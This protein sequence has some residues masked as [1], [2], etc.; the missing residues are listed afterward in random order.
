MADITF[1]DELQFDDNVT[2][3]Q[4]VLTPYSI[5]KIS[6]GE[7]GKVTAS[8]DS[9][10]MDQAEAMGFKK[11]TFRVSK[12]YDKPN[13]VE[14][15]NQLL[16]DKGVNP[17]LAYKVSRYMPYTA[18]EAYDKPLDEIGSYSS[19]PYGA[20]TRDAFSLPGRLLASYFPNEGE[21]TEDAIG[22][23][24]EDK[25]TNFGGSIVRSPSTGVASVLA[26]VAGVVGGVASASPWLAGALEGLTIGAGTGGFNYATDKD[27]TALDALIESVGSALLGSGFKAGSTA[28]MNKAKAMISKAGKFLPQQ[29]DYIYSKL[30]KTTSGTE[31]NLKQAVPERIGDIAN[32]DFTPSKVASKPSAGKLLKEH[33]TIKYITKDESGNILDNVSKDY[34]ETIKQGRISGSLNP[35]Q[36]QAKEAILK[37]FN[38]AMSE[39]KGY[40]GNPTQYL[41]RL[42]EEAKYFYS[43]DPELGQI[44][45]NRIKPIYNE[46][47]SKIARYSDAMGDKVSP[48]NNLDKT[49]ESIDATTRYL[50]NPPQ[51]ETVFK[52]GGIAGLGSIAPDMTPERAKLASRFISGI[53]MPSIVAPQDVM[54]YNRYNTEQ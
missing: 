3:T 32:V 22:R 43:K 8:S 18:Q 15:R 17:E 24:S 27:Y 37:E 30:G 13:D 23:T 47:Y 20:I 29:L 7:I 50:T 49:F 25:G 4:P 19:M 12:I 51:S 28:F 39:L 42:M 5:R 40:E 44:F 36:K 9:D 48:K 38:D 33:N 46:Q 45:L 21:S 35:S 26:P 2:D 16:I 41:D 6:G 1:D 53:R 14:S 52:T 31:Q 10:A 11:G 54:Q 34:I